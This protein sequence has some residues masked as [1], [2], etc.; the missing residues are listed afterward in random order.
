MSHDER[1]Q[2]AHRVQAILRREHE[3]GKRVRVDPDQIVVEESGDAGQQWFYV[4]VDIAPY[5][6]ELG[7]FYELFSRVEEELETEGIDVLLVPQRYETPAGDH[8]QGY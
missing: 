7:T 3:S 2:I 1:R 5:Q 4:P 6:H 8:T